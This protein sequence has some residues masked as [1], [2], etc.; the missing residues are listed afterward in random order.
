MP[1]T[2]LDKVKRRLGI[3]TT[4]Y[5]NLLNDLLTEVD[6][7]INAILA[8]YTQVP[9]EN[10]TWLPILSGIEADWVAGRYR[11]LVEP[12]VLITAAGELREHAF[13]VD[14]RRRLRELIDLIKGEVLRPL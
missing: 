4:D 9:V 6:A 10:P 5:D 1:Y 12:A 3:T 8:R 14:A 7:E 2:S 13:V 11:M